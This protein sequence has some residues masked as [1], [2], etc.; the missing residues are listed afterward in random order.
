MIIRLGEHVKDNRIDFDSWESED[1]LDESDRGALR[2]ARQKEDLLLQIQQLASPNL[3]REGNR[4][5]G[6]LRWTHKGHH[7]LI[8]VVLTLILVLTVIF[9]V[10]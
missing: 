9:F 6:F 5:F 7:R 2:A 1:W 10:V 4:I 8:S 3:A